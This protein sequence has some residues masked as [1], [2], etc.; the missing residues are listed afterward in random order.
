MGKEKT[1]T[2]DDVTLEKFE[3][4]TKACDEAV[5]DPEHDDIDLYCRIMSIM[6][7]ENIDTYYNMSVPAFLKSV[8]R[9]GFFK[10]QPKER[11]T[12]GTYVLGGEK[13]NLT[14]S[15]QHMTAGQYLDFHNTMRDARDN[16]ALLTAIVLI[17]EGKS[18]AQDY[19]VREVA[20]LVREQMCIRDVMGICFFFRM[21]LSVCTKVT[22]DYSLRKLRK[23]LKKEKDPDKARI[24]RK[25]MEVMQEQMK[26][27][28]ELTKEATKRS[29]IG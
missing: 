28:L 8:K 5:K 16:N 29:G 26:K 22:L 1:Y 2:W 10:T 13:Y 23:Q 3:S 11:F 6:D 12:N 20:G 18:Y 14:P 9:I 21:V 7:D 27:N 17:P 15:P 25:S 4:I 19:D 24:I